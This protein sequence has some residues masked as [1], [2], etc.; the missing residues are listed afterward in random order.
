[1]SSSPS[2]VLAIGAH[3]ADMELTAGMVMARYARE[4]HR[5]VLLHLTLGE[6]GHSRL[7]AAEYAAEKRES[8]IAVAHGLGCTSRFM[9]YPDAQLP[10]S[11]EVKLAVCDVIRELKPGVIITH[12]GGSLFRDHARAHRIVVEARFLASLKT[13]ERA[14]PAAPPN[15]L[16]F[17]ENWEDMDGFRPDLY[18]DTTDT[19]DVWLEALGHY[20]I[21]RDPGAGGFRYRDYYSSLS[22]MRGCLSDTDHA[23]ALMRDKDPIEAAQALPL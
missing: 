2:T 7:T 8:A 16:L 22:T 18:V 9:P 15:R 14:L 19:Y 23:V 20:A 21:F 5:A 11:E 3:A 6:K 4:G 10:D 1:M 12:W 13:L 17:T